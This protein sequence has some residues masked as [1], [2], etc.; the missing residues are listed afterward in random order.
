[1]YNYTDL[2]MKIISQII[3]IASFLIMTIACT[4]TQENLK[5]TPSAL[6]VNASETVTFAVH[7]GETEVTGEAQIFLRSTNEELADNT[8]STSIPGEYEF[9]AT[10]NN[11]QSEYVSVKVKEG[12]KLTVDK[13]IISTTGTD[14]ATFTVTQNGV[15]VTNEST[16]YLISGNGEP[17]A[18]DGF[19]FSATV[20][21]M[22]DFYATVGDASTNQV[23]IAAIAGG[24]PDPD[25]YNFKHRGLIVEFT[26]T[27]CGWCAIMKAAMHQIENS[28][29]DNGY[30]VE[31]HQGD[32]MSLPYVNSLLTQFGAG[33][34]SFPL[35]TFN[36]DKKTK[37]VGTYSQT[38]IEDNAD[39]LKLLLESCLD[40]YECTSGISG[41]YFTDENGK[42]KVMAT[43]KIADDGEYRAA[44][45][46]LENG[47][48]GEQANYT[49]DVVDNEEIS[50]HRNVLRAVSNTSEFTGDEVTAGAQGVQG[51]EWTFDKSALINGNP[52]DSHVLIFVTK[53]Q[54]NDKDDEEDDVYVLNNI[55]RCELGETVEFEYAE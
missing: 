26:G 20:T 12:A 19:T 18:L 1:M 36:L 48:N 14:T 41:S 24:D 3:M 54:E 53:K 50:I 33:S 5:L 47:I 35:T 11:I 42:L 37:I 2:N 40:E 46:L 4:P 9:F 49:G 38:S 43:V 25:N 34:T 30:S 15:D 8:F 55:I 44:A 22:Y 27:W 21:G 16:L 23:R 39:R 31:I 10:Y 45:W 13:T 28:G 7:Y 29:Y 17:V 32:S 52:E 51:F 6:E